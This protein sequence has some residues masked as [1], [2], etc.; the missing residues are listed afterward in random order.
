V[1]N[2][3]VATW[4]AGLLGIAVTFV[5]GAGVVLLVRRARVNGGQRTWVAGTDIS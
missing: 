5:I 4:A 2:R 3:Y 1:D